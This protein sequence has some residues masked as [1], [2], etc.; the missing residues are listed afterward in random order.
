M[1]RLFVNGVH[2]SEKNIG[3]RFDPDPLAGD[4]EKQTDR[5]WDIVL[6]Q[7]INR[8][9]VV[10]TNQDDIEGESEELIVVNADYDRQEKPPPADAVR[11][12]RRRSR[13]RRTTGWICSL[14]PTTRPAWPLR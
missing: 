2:W 8:I 10:A 9:Q 11:V 7:R 1:M 13:L 6:T 12:G 5:D 14:R 4:E 3:I